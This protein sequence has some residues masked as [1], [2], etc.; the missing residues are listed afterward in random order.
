[1]KIIYK[2]ILVICLVF[3]MIGCVSVKPVKSL[4]YLRDIID[5]KLIK[6]VELETYTMKYYSKDSWISV[7]YIVNGRVMGFTQW[8]GNNP[9]TIV[10]HITEKFYRTHP[11]LM[12]NIKGYKLY[13]H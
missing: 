11:V 9:K 12:K 1:M 10:S 13:I 6:E 3:I 2:L 4:E 7:D 5:A 8:R